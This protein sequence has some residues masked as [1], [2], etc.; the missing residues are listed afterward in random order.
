MRTFRVWVG[1]VSVLAGMAFSGCSSLRQAETGF[2][3]DYEELRVIHEGANARWYRAEGVRWNDY[4]SAYLERIQF[5]LP[6]Q[7]SSKL[8]E[9]DLESLRSG[10]ADLA[11]DVFGRNYDMNTKEDSSDLVIRVGVTRLDV[12]NVALNAVTGLLAVPVDKGGVGIDLEILEQSS[13][14]RLLAVSAIAKGKLSEVGGFF[15]RFRHALNGTKSIF[16]E[17]GK[18]IGEE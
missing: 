17:V 12:A 9:E 3:E 10:I 5:V 13:Q 14:R 11:R 6:E 7:E 2:L 4:E 1:C 18:T 16:E 15:E 8:S